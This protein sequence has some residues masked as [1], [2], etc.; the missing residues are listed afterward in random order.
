MY[1]VTTQK[2]WL[3]NSGDDFSQKKFIGLGLVLVTETSQ[4][5]LQHS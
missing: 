3:E 2:K 5:P 4:N 1:V